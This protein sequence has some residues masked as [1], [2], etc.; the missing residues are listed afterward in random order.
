LEL[1]G[2]DKA[3]NDQ[4]VWRTQEGT[5]SVE[6]DTEPARSAWQRLAAHLLSFVP[7]ES[8]L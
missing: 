2:N 6:Y 4:L 5:Q 8:E 1:Q 7:W 3:A